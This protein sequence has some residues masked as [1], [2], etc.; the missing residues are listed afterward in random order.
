L[1]GAAL[2]IFVVV[3]NGDYR[4]QRLLACQSEWDGQVVGLMLKEGFGSS[5]PLLAID[6]AGSV[7]YWSELPALDMLG[8]ND[9]YLPRHPPAD[10]GRGF[11][12]HELGDGAYVM[13][14]RPD[15]VLFWDPH[16]RKEAVYRSGREM[17]ARP[18]FQKQYALVNF[19]ARRPYLVRSKIWVRK[20]SER[21]GFVARENLIIIPAHFLNANPETVAYAGPSGPFMIDVALARPAGIH[22]FPIEPGSWRFEVSASA[23][24]NISVGISGAAPSASGEST[25]E[26]ECIADSKVFVDLVLSCDGPGIAGVRG[27]WLR[28]VTQDRGNL[29]P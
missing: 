24:V 18:E 11:L 7:P 2:A 13:K 28:R 10:L 17:Q 23:P 8:L 29:V 21:A 3:Q 27:V 6:A 16:G 22:H 12:G 14:R 26:F 19:E 15:L 25:V 1:A 5:R 20:A 4:N 9:D